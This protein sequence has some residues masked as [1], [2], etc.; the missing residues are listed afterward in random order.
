MSLQSLNFYLFNF[1]LLQFRPS[2]QICQNKDQG[3][4]DLKKTN[5]QIQNLI[6]VHLPICKKLI[7][8]MML[9]IF[10]NWH[11]LNIGCQCSSYHNY[12]IQSKM[13]CC[14]TTDLDDL[15][16]PRYTRVYWD[17]KVIQSC[18]Q[19]PSTHSLIYNAENP[20]AI[21]PSLSLPSLP[22]PPCF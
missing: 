1:C 15:L 13:L 4:I 3:Q 11:P 6:L 22:P 9:V 19:L 2:N 16:R 20:F 12:D 7:H 10:Y 21:R 17:I 18:R 8:L 5:K 14:I